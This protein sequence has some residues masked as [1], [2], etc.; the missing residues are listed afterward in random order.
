MEWIT[1]FAAGVIV[2][3]LGITAGL[4]IAWLKFLH[5]K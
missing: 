2:F 1:P 5:F 4:V 3:A